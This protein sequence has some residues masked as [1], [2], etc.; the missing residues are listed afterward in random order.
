VQY[1]YGFTVNATTGCRQADGR[2]KNSGE[3]CP[4]EK[5]WGGRGVEDSLTFKENEV[6]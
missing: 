5:R 1:N 4:E 3:L 6:S 2:E